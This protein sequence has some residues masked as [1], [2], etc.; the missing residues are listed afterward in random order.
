MHD[1]A[2]QSTPP[3]LA[4]T[5]AASGWL[6]GFVRLLVLTSAALLGVGLVAP[7]MTIITTFGRYDSWLRL[8]APDI[9]R[10]ER[11]TYSLLGGIVTLI[12]LGNIGIGVLLV[13]FTCIFPTL[14][15]MLMAWATQTLMAGRRAGRLLS[16][17]H[18]AGKFSMLDVLV[19][20]LLILAIK[21]LPG[22]SELWLEWGVWAFAASVILSLAASLLLTRME[23][24]Q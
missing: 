10:E 21:G 15:L 23:H 9:I 6:G 22:S 5:A 13:A 1:E 4:Q 16:L 8:L 17:A 19:L 11:S 18:H 20:A 2:I 24:R 7:S 3:A 14:K 12:E